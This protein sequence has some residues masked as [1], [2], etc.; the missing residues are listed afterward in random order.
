MQTSTVKHFIDGLTAIGVEQQKE[1]YLTLI[2]EEFNE[3]K[4]AYLNF[5]FSMEKIALVEVLDGI[6]DTIW[7]YAGANH[8]NGTDFFEDLDHALISIK[9][10]STHWFDIKSH[11]SQHIENMEFGFDNKET[12]IKNCTLLWEFG[13]KLGCHMIP[14]WHEVSMSNMSKLNQPLFRAD[15]K[16][17]KNPDTF[18]PANFLKYVTWY[19]V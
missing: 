19:K 18:I 15:K 17:L 2:N 11:F 4:I 1:L 8:L 5:A 3:L 12:I 7:V 16:L 9:T 14:A 10:P 6:V 13:Q